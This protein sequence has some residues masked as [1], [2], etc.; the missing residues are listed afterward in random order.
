[1]SYIPKRLGRA[2]A[3]QIHIDVVQDRKTNKK[4]KYKSTPI[5]N[6]SIK[7]HRVI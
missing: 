3:L 2:I 7:I 6:I 4:K 1:M 5:F